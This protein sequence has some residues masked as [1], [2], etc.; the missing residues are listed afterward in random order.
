MDLFVCNFLMHKRFGRV[1]FQWKNK[2]KN[3]KNILICALKMKESHSEI[4]SKFH[5]YLQR[6][7]LNKK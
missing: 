6:N 7:T 1:D 2:K 5:K 3:I 4:A